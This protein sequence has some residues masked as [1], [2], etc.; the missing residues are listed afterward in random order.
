MVPFRLIATQDESV[1][2]SII[3]AT[4]RQ[5]EVK[6]EHLLAL[7]DFGKKL[8]QFFQTFPNGKRLFYERRSRQFNSVSGIEKTRIVTHGKSD[9]GLRCDV[10]GGA[11]SYNSKLRRLA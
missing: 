11:S 8:E 3:K 10:S 9:Q 5:T 1:T 2:A 6:E 7:S 4:N